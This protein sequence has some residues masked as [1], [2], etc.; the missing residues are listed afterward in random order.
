MEINK[1]LELFSGD[2]LTIAQKV[3]FCKWKVNKLKEFLKAANKLRGDIVMQ[4]KKYLLK[5]PHQ[6]GMNFVVVLQTRYQTKG[7]FQILKN[8]Q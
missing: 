8:G 7:K 3:D 5:E 2:G 4:I 1:F 6:F